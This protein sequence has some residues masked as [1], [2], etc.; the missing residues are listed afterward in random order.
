MNI[1]SR[2]LL[3]STLALLLTLAIPSVASATCP[4]GKTHDLKFK[5]KSDGCVEKVQKN[6]DDSDADDTSVCAADTVTWKVSG[7]K[8]SVVFEGDS[9]FD[10][11]DSGN[12][13]NK[14]EGV[15]KSGAAKNGQRTEYKYSVT[16]EG[17]SCVFDPKIIVDP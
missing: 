5:V 1:R 11:V 6:S 17:K 16:V 7:P 13:G 10:W 15:V 12:Q 14:I 2:S 9:P 8:K 3:T 4:G